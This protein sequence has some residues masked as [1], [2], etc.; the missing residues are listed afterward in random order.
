MTAT[1]QIWKQDRKGSVKFKFGFFVTHHEVNLLQTQIYSCLL[2]YRHH[3]AWN[4]LCFLEFHY[5]H[6][7]LKMFQ[8]KFGHLKDI[9]IFY[10]TISQFEL[11]ESQCHSGLK[12]KLT[13]MGKF[14]YRL[15]QNEM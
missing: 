8:I 11:Q 12:P 6:T 3:N 10:D 1:K 4:N 9:Y 15:C 14:Q 13:S 7:H 2:H 5:M